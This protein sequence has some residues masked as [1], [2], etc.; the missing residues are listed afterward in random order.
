MRNSR[1]SVARDI[2]GQLAPIMVG[3]AAPGFALTG[4]AHHRFSRVRSSAVS[5]SVH[6]I[7]ISLWRFQPLVKGFRA[8]GILFQGKGIGLSHHG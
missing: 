1:A 3:L 4:L 8:L 2:R 7:E 5:N 6:G